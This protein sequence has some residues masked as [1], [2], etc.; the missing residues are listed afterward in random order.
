MFDKNNCDMEYMKLSAKITVCRYNELSSDEK[1]LVDEARAALLT[2]YAPYSGFRV[3]AAA[4]LA[5]GRIVRGSNQEN[6]SFPAGLCAE[7]TALFSAGTLAPDVPVEAIALAAE[8]D[9]VPTLAPITPC[10]I[11]RQVMLETENRYKKPLRILMCGRD[12]VYIASSVRD[13]L[14]LAF[15]L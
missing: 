7:R 13:L 1:F 6:A 8:A 12:E 14:P 10:G 4:R 11:C 5:D 15:S 9:G 3:G 2:A